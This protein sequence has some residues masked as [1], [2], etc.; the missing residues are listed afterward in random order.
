[1]KMSGYKEK[2]I[3]GVLKE[4]ETGFPIVDRCRQKELVSTPSIVT[5]PSL[6]A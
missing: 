4:A 5:V 3:I 2:K 6:A 1:M